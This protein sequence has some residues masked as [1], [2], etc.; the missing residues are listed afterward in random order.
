MSQAL[1]HLEHETAR[2]SNRQGICTLGMNSRQQSQKVVRYSVYAGCS[3]QLQTQQ[4][5]KLSRKG[6]IDTP[7]F[8]F[9]KSNCSLNQ[10]VCRGETKVPGKTEPGPCPHP[11]WPDVTMSGAFPSSLCQTRKNTSLLLLL[12]SQ[13]YENKF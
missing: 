5:C 9:C 13:G 7:I 10:I 11:Q 3:A 12:T 1:R 6:V 4:P 8:N 2:L